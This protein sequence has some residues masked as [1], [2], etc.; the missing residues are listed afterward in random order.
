M[1]TQLAG[2]NRKKRMLELSTTEIDALP[3]ETPVYNGVGKMLVPGM[4]T[5]GEG[6]A[7]TSP[8]LS[9]LRHRM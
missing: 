9:A 5:D 7:D 1:R 6:F 2:Q 4:R 3:T 8:G